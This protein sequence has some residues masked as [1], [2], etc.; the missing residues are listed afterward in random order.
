[1]LIQAIEV[2]L[3]YLNGPSGLKR[4]FIRSDIYYPLSDRH[5]NK[6]RIMNYLLIDERVWHD[7]QMHVRCIEEKMR[8]MNRHF[9]PA[10]CDG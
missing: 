5:L 6:H 2:F 1:M 8:Q 9:H 10:G 3:V 4:S 7:L